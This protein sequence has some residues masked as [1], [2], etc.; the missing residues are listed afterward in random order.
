MEEQKDF[1]KD[2][3]CKQKRTYPQNTLGTIYGLGFIGACVYFIG[4]AATF[5]L[6]VLG[7]LKALVWPAFLVYAALKY[8]GM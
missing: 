8:F 5:W 3:C 4:T 6:G 7:F 2:E 1:Q